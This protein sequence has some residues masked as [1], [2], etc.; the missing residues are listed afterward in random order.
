MYSPFI[1]YGAFVSLLNTLKKLLCPLPVK[2]CWTKGCSVAPNLLV[3]NKAVPKIAGFGIAPNKY[4]S[5][6]WCFV[7]YRNQI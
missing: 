7:N 3:P 6:L 2:F 1:E 4:I 5:R